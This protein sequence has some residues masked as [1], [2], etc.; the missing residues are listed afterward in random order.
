MARA[1]DKETSGTDK[2]QPQEVS[3]A[4]DDTSSAQTENLRGDGASDRYDNSQ[5]GEIEGEDV[6]KLGVKKPDAM[7]AG[8]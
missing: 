3:S 8:G 6:E 7:G 1:G 4:A 5:P 2:A